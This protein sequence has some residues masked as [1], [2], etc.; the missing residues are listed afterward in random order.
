MK[1]AAR[2]LLWA[3]GAAGLAIALAIVLPFAFGGRPYTVLSGSMEPAISP[4]DVVISMRIDPSEARPGDVVTFRDPKDPDRL[5]THR[6]R[7]TRPDGRRVRFVTKGDAN[8]N[9]EEWRVAAGGHVSRVAYRVPAVGRLALTAQSRGGL[10]A[11]IVVPL[12]LL[13]AH[14]ITRIW[15]PAQGASGEAA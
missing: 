3:G 4:G 6:V 1:A 9:T 15:R 2:F 10:I 12:L 7:S 13:G 14:E 11:L 5:V 8:N